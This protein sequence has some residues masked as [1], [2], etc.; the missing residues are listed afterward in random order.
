[1]QPPARARPQTTGVVELRCRS[2][3]ETRRDWGISGP[4][5]VAGHEAR[6][7][8]AASF[9]PKTG[10]WRLETWVFET[11]SGD[12]R[13]ETLRNAPLDEALDVA[14]QLP[15][16]AVAEGDGAAAGARATGAADA[17]DVALGHVRQ[18]EV[19]DVRD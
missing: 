9:W 4:R 3:G 10:D 7:P 14:Q 2:S 16:L 15:L 8:N 17:V 1:L 5:L 18:V 19:D 13:L 6:R 11:V 12:R